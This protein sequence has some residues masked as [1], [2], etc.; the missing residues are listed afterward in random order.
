MLN[1]L[2]LGCFCYNGDAV[3]LFLQEEMEKDAQTTIYDNFKFL[4]KDDLEKLNL[5]SLIGTN[6]LRAS[7]HG[8]FIDYKLDKKV[9]MVTHVLFLCYVW[10]IV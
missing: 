3:F 10:N 4:T 6:L 5:T 1:F 2:V 8:F 7:M 9:S